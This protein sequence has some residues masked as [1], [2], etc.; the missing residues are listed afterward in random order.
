MPLSTDWKV[1]ALSLVKLESWAAI[2]IP[3]FLTPVKCS[4]Y[5]FNS[6][7]RGWPDETMRMMN[8]NYKVSVQRERKT[9]LIRF[10]S[11]LITGVVL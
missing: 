5:Y 6:S 8:L 1:E 4:L 11:S 10:L 3:G 9:Q 2:F 7:R